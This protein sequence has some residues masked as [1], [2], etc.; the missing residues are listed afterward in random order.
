[1]NYT[2]IAKLIPIEKREET[3]DKLVNVILTSKNDE[4]MPPNLANMI[5]YYWQ[6]NRLTNDSGLSALLK[7]AVLLEKEK[8]L[9]VL[10]NL[11]LSEIAEKL[12]GTLHG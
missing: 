6:Q 7:A 2:R 3:A 8:T 9:Q 4:K 1:V 5:L 11:Q 10:N 12:E